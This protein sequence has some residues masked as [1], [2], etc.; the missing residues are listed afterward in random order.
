MAFPGTIPLGLS[1][2]STT[3][4]TRDH[5]RRRAGVGI[6]TLLAGAAIVTWLA[7]RSAPTTRTRAVPPTP[8]HCR[9]DAVSVTNG[10]YVGG[11]TQEEA[12]A[13]TI[14]NTSNHTCTLHGYVVLVAYDARGV[15]LPFTL[16]HH[17][18]GGWPMATEVPPPFRVAPGAAGYV[19]FAQIACYTGYSELSRHVTVTIPATRVSTP[20]IL[21]TPLALCKG[22]SATV[23]NVIAM[24]P[25]E[26][27]VAATEGRVP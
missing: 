25:I 24:S 23:G 2:R 9:A 11:A 22:P 17:S 18:T 1:Y 7:T 12:H 27:T 15:A 5:H 3:V 10:P 21:R 19:F 26:P 8:A 4:S 6:A 13:I 16:A 14:T 20:L